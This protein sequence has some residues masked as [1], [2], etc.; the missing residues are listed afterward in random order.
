[1]YGVFHSQ[2]LKIGERGFAHDFFHSA[3]QSSFACTGGVCGF[4]EGKPFGESTSCQ[5]SNCWTI[6]SECVRWSL[7]IVRPGR[8]SCSQP[9]AVCHSQREIH[10]EVNGTVHFSAHA[11]FLSMDR[12]SSSAHFGVE[13][14]GTLRSL[15]PRTIG[16]FSIN[17]SSIDTAQHCIGAGCPY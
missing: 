3:G 6:G 4:I 11:E 7:R 9:G 15:V 8:E 1:M 17:V 2:I 16:R 13:I 10:K 12:T 5:R 14:Y